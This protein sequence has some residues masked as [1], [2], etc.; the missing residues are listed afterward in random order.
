MI[1]NV[2][3]SAAAGANAGS[4]CTG[5][6]VRSGTTRLLVDCGPG[7]LPELKRLTDVRLID[8]IVVSHM[9]ID[10]ILDLITLRAA[11]RYAPEPYNGRIPLWLPPGGMEILDSLAAPLDLDNHSPALFRPGLRHPRIQSDRFPSGGRDFR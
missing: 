3:G 4:G 1:V 11:L 7:I 5:Y 9:H 8:A 10:H 6:L 2:L